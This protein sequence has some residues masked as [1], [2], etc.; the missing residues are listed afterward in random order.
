MA[1]TIFGKKLAKSEMFMN[2]QL[3]NNP[4]DLNLSPN[5]EF[6]LSLGHKFILPPPPCLNTI[7]SDVKNLERKI[8]L[9]RKF[10]NSKLPTF[11][12]PNP[13]YRPPQNFKVYFDKVLCEI[14]N[15]F[16]RFKGNAR[17]PWRREVIDGITK[18]KERKNIVIKPADKNLGLTVMDKD[19]YHNQ[20]RGHLEDE[21]TYKP[22]TQD[23]ILSSIS[24]YGKLIDSLQLEW[25]TEKF[26]YMKLDSYTIPHFYILPKLHKN[27]ISSRPICSSHS[28]FSTP[29]C[30]YLNKILLPISQEL[31]TVC[32][33]SKQVTEA[34]KATQ[35][36]W[37]DLICT[38]DVTSLYP[39]I[40]TDF[41]L[42]LLRPFLK[43]FN[44]IMPPFMDSDRVIKILAFLL[45]NH[46]VQYKG[47]IF[48]QIS[49]T[50]M[51]VQFAPAYANI[52]MHVLETRKLQF[53]DTGLTPTLYLRY[54]DDVLLIGKK[55]GVDRIKELF[56]QLHPNIKFTWE[57]STNGIPFL[58]LDIY[59]NP[60]GT[61]DYKPYTKRISKFLYIPFLSFHTM[62]AK[63][64][65]IKTELLRLATL[66][67]TPQVFSEERDRFFIRL[68]ARGYPVEF[69]S[70][71]LDKY[72]SPRQTVAQQSADS[73][74]R[75]KAEN[76]LVLITTLSHF[77][78]N[79]AFRS[80]FDQNLQPANLQKKIL[81][82]YRHPRSI[83][84][85]LIRASTFSDTA[86]PSDN[87]D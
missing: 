2:N 46:Y 58:D 78:Y 37:D 31:S 11:R 13:S 48:K 39:N 72:Q 62:E 17:H 41:A 40:P 57:V 7:D 49:G 23:E 32:H 79:L 50:A 12:V 87:V 16:H 54:I 64:S 69:L 60:Y 27:P 51:G 8:D 70:T 85:L 81:V 77:T 68:R 71:E 19:W 9:V 66:S 74:A 22:S 21:K 14:K 26:L 67:S 29:L 65:M 55:G 52:F 61:I 75:P 80:I 30:I 43:K 47:D 73:I 20:V 42:R 5:E 83:G 28:N 10:G 36:P 18:L 82:A 4:S 34:L 56:S 63:K 38:A 15:T 44:H 45:R 6:V 59:R 76:P 84:K 3:F 25:N 1:I 24:E 53:L 33:S 35:V 86:E